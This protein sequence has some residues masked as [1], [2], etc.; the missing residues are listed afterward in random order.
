MQSPFCG[1]QAPA[2][3]PVH[4]ACVCRENSIAAWNR[5]TLDY[6]TVLTC[7]NL[8]RK[9]FFP[10]F[11][12]NNNCVLMISL[13][14]SRHNKM[15]RSHYSLVSTIPNQD[16]REGQPFKAHLRLSYDRSKNVA[17]V[18]WQPQLE[19]RVL[20]YRGLPFEIPS[21]FLLNVNESVFN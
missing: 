12:M 17:L 10:S 1:Y 15:M 9:Y 8:F 2:T 16:D 7:W 14:F 6:H 18:Y 3:F 5:E 13:F 20:S 19:N 21:M 11:R 4:T